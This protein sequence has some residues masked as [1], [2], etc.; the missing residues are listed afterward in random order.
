MFE[1]LLKFSLNPR[2]LLAIFVFCLVMGLIGAVVYFGWAL[3]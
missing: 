2:F 1:R 3:F